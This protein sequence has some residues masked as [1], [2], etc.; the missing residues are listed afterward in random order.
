M[1]PTL[2][3][4]IHVLIKDNTYFRPKISKLGPKLQRF[5]SKTFKFLVENKYHLNKLIKKIVANE[6]IQI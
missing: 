6:A 2:A 3:K 1:M 4:V 5:W